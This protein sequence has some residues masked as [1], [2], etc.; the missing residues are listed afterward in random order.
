MTSGQALRKRILE[1]VE[2]DDVSGEVL[3]DAIASTAD[4]VERLEA[5]IT[6]EGVTIKGARGQ[7]IAHPA[8]TP[9]AKYQ[10]LL[11]ELVDKAFPGSGETVTQRAARAARVRWLREGVRR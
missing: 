4:L 2:P 11:V 8:L 9:L 10:R 5:A 3:L 7:I 6:K 1:D